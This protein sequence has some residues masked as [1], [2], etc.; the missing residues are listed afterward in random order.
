MRKL[1]ILILLSLSFIINVSAKNSIFIKSSFGLDLVNNKTRAFINE[2]LA[3]YSFGKNIKFAP[4]IEF[5]YFSPIYFSNF[6]R[7]LDIYS[8]GIGPG[9]FFSFDRFLLDIKTL[10]VIN[11]IN[12]YYFSSFNLGLS[13]AYKFYK[14]YNFSIYIN[15][16]IN[17]FYNGVDLIKHSFNFGPGFIIQVKV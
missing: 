15:L 11:F 5:N 14:S 16:A 3:P 2:S 9:V 4:I 8:L 17:Y 1:T 6:T 13:T 12:D 10:Y 7:I